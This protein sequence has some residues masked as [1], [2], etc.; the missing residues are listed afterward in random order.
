M[1]VDGER[2]F[3]KA[4]FET[5]RHTLCI[6]SVSNRS[7]GGKDPASGL[8]GDDGANFFA[9]HDAEDVFRVLQREDEHGDVVVH[10]KGSRRGVHDGQMLGKDFVIGDGVI[11]DGIGIFRRVGRID[12]VDVLGQQNRVGIDLC[13][14]EHRARVGREIGVACAAAEDDDA[15]LLQMPDGLAADVGLGDLVHLDGRLDAD[16]DVIGGVCDVIR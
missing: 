7:I 6:S 1:V 13:R 2:F 15:A 8:L 14:A 4:R 3:V 9:H 10:G 11:F 16:F 5:R 12:A